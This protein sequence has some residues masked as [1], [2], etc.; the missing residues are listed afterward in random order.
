M[1]LFKKL[2]KILLLLFLLSVF[3][4]IGYYFAVTKGVVLEP[5][6]LIL[7]ED[8]AIVYDANERTLQ[9]VSA[10]YSKEITPIEKIGEKTKLAFV[11]T[12]DRRFFS[13]GGFD[14]KRIARAAIKNIQTLSFKEGASTI[15][16]QLIKN[17]HLSQQKTIKRKLQEMKLTYRLEKDYSK[18]EILEKYLN[19][20]YFGHSCF[21]ITSA[22]RY[23]FDKTPSELTLGESAILAGIVKSPNNYSP[24]KHPEKCLQRRNLILSIMRDLGHITAAEKEAAQREDL[25]LSPT[26]EK[27]A[28]CYISAVFDELERISEEKNFTLSQNIKVYTYL[29]SDLQEFIEKQSKQADCDASISVLDNSSHG[30]KGYYSTTGAIQ[31][32]PASVIKPLLVYAPAI[33]ENFLSPATPILDEAT[34]FSGYAP[35]NYDNKYHG[36][37]SA[38]QALANSLNVPAVKILNSVGVKKSAEYIKQMGLTVDESDYS[39]TLA[40]GGMKNGFSLNEILGA[41]STFSAKGE[42]IPPAFI[43]KVTANDAT[44]YERKVNAQK[45]F[46]EDTA[47]LISDMLK[48]AAKEGTAK[49]LHAFPFDIAAKTGTN[50][51]KKGNLDAY[52]LSYTTL[53]SVGVWLGNADNTPISYTGGGLPCNISYAIHEKLKDGYLKNNISIP[54]FEQPKTVEKIAIDKIEYQNSRKILL[55]DKISPTEYKFFELFK[56]TAR[57]TTNATHFSNPTIPTPTIKVESNEIN[58]TFDIN[59]HKFYRFLVEKHYYAT[60]NSYVS[61]STV[62]DGPFKNAIADIIEADKSYVYTVTPIYKDIKGKPI[63][64]PAITGKNIQ[65]LNPIRPSTPPDISYKDWWNY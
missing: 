59:T 1:R 63:S 12:E 41:Y 24:F 29:D 32:S 30:F 8:T 34:S 21:G 50:G 49:K 38:R 2:L 16:Q 36:Y 28:R 7:N 11:D 43:K 35:K 25:P 9:S 58:I 23:Y 37:V 39:L 33:E 57:P 14:F 47:Y 56:T 31:R 3:F 27:G 65:E 22:A 52:S 54:N 10:L 19:T 44:V 6:K 55:A 45:V 20:I 4:F 42:F 5:K 40:L 46:S 51:A 15:S 60:H 13:H 53:D 64:L 26:E 18:E 17:T 62:Y 61:H 48:T